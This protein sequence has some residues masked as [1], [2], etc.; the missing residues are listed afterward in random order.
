MCRTRESSYHQGSR[1][2]KKRTA[3]TGA[4]RKHTKKPTLSLCLLGWSAVKVQHRRAP[5]SGDLRIYLPFHLYPQAS[6]DRHGVYIGS[7][8]LTPLHSKGVL[9]AGKTPGTGLARTSTFILRR[10]DVTDGVHSCHETGRDANPRQTH[11][12]CHRIFSLSLT[13]YPSCGFPPAPVA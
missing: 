11:D 7:H 5:C 12:S 6:V 4:D 2:Q 10:H 3:D 13:S 1:E 8:E 9:R